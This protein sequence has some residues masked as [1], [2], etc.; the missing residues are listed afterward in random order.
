LEN[1]RFPIDNWK[2]RNSTSCVFLKELISQ[3]WQALMRNAMAQ[4]YSWPNSA[5]EYVKVYER[6]VKTVSI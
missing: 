4:D 5:R 6:A 2:F 3:S 1:R